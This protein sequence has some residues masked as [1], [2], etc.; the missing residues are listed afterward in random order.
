MGEETKQSKKTNLTVNVTSG[1]FPVNLWKHWDEDCKENFGDCRWMKMWHDH[2]M[3]QSY[4]RF[5]EM[6]EETA[7]LKEELIKS[8]TE[9]KETKKKVKTLKGDLEVKENG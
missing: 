9:K 5:L 6:Y 1:A 7:Y 2:L 3:S 4:Q 8:Q